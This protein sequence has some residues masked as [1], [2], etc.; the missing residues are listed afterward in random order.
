MPS[1][2][3]PNEVEYEIVHP[4]AVKLLFVVPLAEA[5]FWFRLGYVVFSRLKERKL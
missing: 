1:A 4:T 2:F 5:Q 3:P